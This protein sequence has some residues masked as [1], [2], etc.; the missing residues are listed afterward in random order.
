MD[1]GR[2][3][4]GMV[5]EI[6]AGVA[7]FKPKDRCY[8]LKVGRCSAEYQFR[9]LRSRGKER[10]PRRA[11]VVQNPRDPILANSMSRLY[12]GRS[13]PLEQTWTR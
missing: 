6:N 1:K 8:A 9:L 12:V 13:S 7:L 2:G 5:L 10:L 11:Q 3:L 4:L